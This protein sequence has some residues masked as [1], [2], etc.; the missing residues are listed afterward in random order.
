MKCL[1]CQGEIR[2]ETKFCLFCG[3]QVPRC[4]ECGTLLTKRMRYC[5]KD[6]TK[7]PEEFLEL[8]P[9]QVQEPAQVPAEP[10]KEQPMPAE[11]IKE[12]PVSAEPIKEQPV[13]A[14]EPR[15]EQPTLPETKPVKTKKK[16]A[17]ILIGI[18]LVVWLLGLGGAG[19]YV[20]SK[21]YIKLPEIKKPA[22]LDRLEEMGDRFRDE[23]TVPVETASEE[24][25]PAVTEEAP[26]ETDAAEAVAEEPMETD[27]PVEEMTEEIA[28]VEAVYL[29]QLSYTY[30]RGKVWKRGNEPA[31][32]TVHTKK[33]APSCWSDTV[34][35]G[36]TEG[37][38]TDS[39]GNE[40]TYGIHV[41][42]STSQVYSITYDL[43]GLYTRF[44]GVCACPDY[45]NAISAYVSSY[46]K[47]FEI[48]GD[49]KLL[50]VSDTMR[51][52]REA[53]VFT[54]DVTG[55]RELTLQY[56]ATMGPN[57]IAT[58]YDGLLQ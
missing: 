27:P 25:G 52:G 17:P 36:Y 6:G 16:T 9:E 42:G 43:D 34:T 26:E 19:Y 46:D 53:Q 33:H 11:P 23:E 57:E 15:E 55:V 47:Y 58:L 28:A 3:Q 8:F 29:N 14:E 39:C 5:I 18:L 24:P 1:K 51:Y 7:I 50:F 10:T 2:E 12:Q 22:V 35:P 21:G 49:G 31:E 45:M 56:P 40:Y 41:D 48:Y 20:F 30:A 13:P 4:P 38:V 54:L 44:S 32:M 37:P